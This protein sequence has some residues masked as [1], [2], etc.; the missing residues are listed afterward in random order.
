MT[1]TNF[2]A[3]RAKFNREAILSATPAALLTMLYDRLLLDLGRAEAAQQREDWDAARENLLH[4]QDIVAELSGSLDLDAWTGAR[5]MFSLYTYVNGLLITANINR[6]ISHTQESI[7][8]LGP[9]R[10]AWHHAAE[11]AAA[12]RP[13][14]AA[15]GTL[16][17]G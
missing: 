3:Q 7:A 12:D 4:A 17:I 1:L 10:E 5:D 8:V 6:N 14:V 13:V 2:A 11:S 15:N 16:G 9:L